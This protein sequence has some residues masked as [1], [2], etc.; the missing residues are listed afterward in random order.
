MWAKFDEQQ[1]DRIRESDGLDAITR[2]YYDA[3]HGM[4][5]RMFRK[6]KLDIT[7]TDAVEVACSYVEVTSQGDFEV[8]LPLDKP[9]PQPH[10]YELISSDW[11]GYT[12]NIRLKPKA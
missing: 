3:V 4:L 6:D 11:D 8:E 10:Q 5:K 2:A 12:V 7:I 9:K 1:Q